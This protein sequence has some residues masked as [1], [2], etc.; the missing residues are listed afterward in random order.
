MRSW[1]RLILGLISC[2]R[3][4]GRWWLLLSMPFLGA[5]TSLSTIQSFL[6]QSNLPLM[7]SFRCRHQTAECTQEVSRRGTTLQTQKPTIKEHLWEQTKGTLISSSPTGFHV[8]PLIESL[9]IATGF[10]KICARNCWSCSWAHW[11][12]T[13]SHTVGTQ[14]IHSF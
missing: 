1:F 12:L 9:A 13:P 8:D 14:T 3:V 11:N 10:G 4:T 5:P 7:T 6:D 2:A